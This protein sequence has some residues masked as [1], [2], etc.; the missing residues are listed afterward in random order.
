MKY[1]GLLF[2]GTL[3]L[4]SCSSGSFKNNNSK[5]CEKIYYNDFAWVL[6]DTFKSVVNSDTIFFNE[7]KFECVHSSFYIQKAMFDRFGKWNKSIK[8]LQRST[9]LI[10]EN[11]T[12]F[13]NDTIQFT[14]AGMGEENNKTIFASVM[15]FN[16]NNNDMLA[17][18]SPYRERL[19]NY[20]SDA[21]RN[22]KIQKKSFYEA[23]WKTFDPERWEEIQK[24]NKSKNN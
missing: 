1:F 21:I 8:P 11:V 12:L 17:V 6:Q 16:Q 14:V 19:I 13:E 20:F 7:I 24:Y 3:V 4:S 23:Y 15:V 9:I 10:W 5:R 2:L 18:N 22:D